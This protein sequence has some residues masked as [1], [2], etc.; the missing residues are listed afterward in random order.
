MTNLSIGLALLAAA[1][2]L[3]LFA[4]SRRRAAGLPPG[5]I[6]SRDTGCWRS[7]ERPLYDPEL[8]LT[9]KPDYVV[10]SDGTLIPVEVK[11]GQA[12]RTPYNSHVHQLAAY[13]L[14]VERTTGRRPPYGILHYPGLDFVV[15][16]T[17]ALE[18]AT[19]DLI[20]RLRS[21]GRLPDVPRSHDDPRRCTRCGF[22]EACDQ[23]AT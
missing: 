5:R 21:D 11:S 14:L 16:F 13:C 2:L 4:N 20:S 17:P 15:D 1:L 8:G 7:V 22:R 18:N 6:I 3:L 12:P 23:R 10:E 19:L 9:G